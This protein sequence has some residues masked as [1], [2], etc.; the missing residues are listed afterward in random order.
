MSKIV[1]PTKMNKGE[2]L[3]FLS[4]L[5]YNTIDYMICRSNMEFNA[6][7][8]S[9]SKEGMPE[10]GF[11]IR[12]QRDDQ[13]NL[14]GFKY[15]FYLGIK[16]ESKLKEIAFELLEKGYTIIVSKT[17]EPNDT[18]C[19]GNAV[20]NRRDNVLIE[21]IHGPGTVR[22]LEEKTPAQENIYIFANP[23]SPAW[24]RAIFMFMVNEIATE[25]IIVE[26]SYYPY[27]V[28]KK[29]QKLILWELRPYK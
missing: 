18:I 25:D 8:H 1:F 27:P 11:S 2:S 29:E 12:T 6:F 16:D 20:I 17:L 14:K 15:P 9:R 21:Y 10:C 7:I 4:N 13:D 28:G 24:L 3:D 26:W 22:Q 19:K 23:K 5:G